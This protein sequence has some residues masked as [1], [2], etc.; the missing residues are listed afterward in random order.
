M[1]SDYSF[2]PRFRTLGNHNCFIAQARATIFISRLMMLVVPYN[3]NPAQKKK[4]SVCFPLETPMKSTL[5]AGI[6][7]VS[8]K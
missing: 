3:V 8:S 4:K 6:E 7:A 1:F 2:C 5:A